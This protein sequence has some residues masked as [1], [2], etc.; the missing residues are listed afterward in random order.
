MDGGNWAS[1]IV[2]IVVL[3]SAISSGRQASKASTTNSK[4]L[5]ETEAYGRARAIDT[6]TIERQEKELVKLRARVEKL[7][8][9]EDVSEGEKK[10]LRRE[11][12][13]LRRR[14]TILEEKERSHG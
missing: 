6:A 13:D 10:D 5:A 14:V 8:E 11:N 12:E 9:D 7:E 1:I 2:A 3:I 4:V